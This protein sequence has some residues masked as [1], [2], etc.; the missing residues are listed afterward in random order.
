MSPW[1]SQPVFTDHCLQTIGRWPDGLDVLHLH[2][3]VAVAGL[4]GRGEE[5]GV[6][7]RRG[8]DMADWLADDGRVLDVLDL[9]RSQV[10]GIVE[11]HAVGR[12]PA[13]RL[14]VAL[15]VDQ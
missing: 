14:H 3:A 12:I 8:H 10:A 2:R 6:L 9:D 7:P 4:A 5:G 1:G 11:E 13:D 15:D